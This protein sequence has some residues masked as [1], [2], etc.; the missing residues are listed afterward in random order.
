MI[1]IR[2]SDAPMHAALTILDV[3]PGH[4]DR[5]TRL[6][7]MG[8]VVGSHVIVRQKRPAVIVEYDAT[9]LALDHEVAREVIVVVDDIKDGVD[10]A[11]AQR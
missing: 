5:A 3:A 6:A 8:L 7:A 1:G 10:E 4:S 2:M 9:V 11:T